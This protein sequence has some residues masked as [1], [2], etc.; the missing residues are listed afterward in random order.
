MTSG[1]INTVSVLEAAQ[2]FFLEK[3]YNE[4]QIF[5]SS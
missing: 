3:I 1:L 5:N 4:K 2:R